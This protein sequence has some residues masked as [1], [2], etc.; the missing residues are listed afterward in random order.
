MAAKLL[1]ELAG[2]GP[3]S[4]VTSH[5]SEA[6]EGEQLEPQVKPQTRAKVVLTQTP[7]W[8]VVST[9]IPCRRV[10]FTRP[11]N[12]VTWC[13]TAQV[14]QLLPNCDFHLRAAETEHDCN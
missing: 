13:S 11:S 8:R 5:N 12:N 7:I 2:V 1:I 3:T 10:Q 6:G 9:F 14:R 4:K